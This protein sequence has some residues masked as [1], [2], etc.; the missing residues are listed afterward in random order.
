VVTG[1]VGNK[2]PHGIDYTCY[3]E[4]ASRGLYCYDWRDNHG[5]YQLR[6]APEQPLAVDALPDDL[7][8]VASL[9]S[10]DIRLSIVSPSRRRPVAQRKTSQLRIALICSSR[11]RTVES[12]GVVTAS[13]KR[14]TIGMAHVP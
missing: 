13:G 3:Y 2:A 5:P 1:F 14:P 4:P 10:F 11:D 7:Q 9:A 6:A 12:L 8:V